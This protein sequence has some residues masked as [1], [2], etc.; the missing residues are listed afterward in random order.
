MEMLG[1]HEIPIGFSMAL[2]KDTNA[3]NSFSAMPESQRKQVIEA[4]RTIQTKQ[5]MERFVNSI[6]SRYNKTF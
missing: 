2:A 1:N 5:D 3:M 6:T 4:S